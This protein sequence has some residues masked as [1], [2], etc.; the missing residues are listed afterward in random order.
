MRFMMKLNNNK[1][2]IIINTH[3]II[4]LIYIKKEY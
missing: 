3:I 4:D 1:Y 2:K